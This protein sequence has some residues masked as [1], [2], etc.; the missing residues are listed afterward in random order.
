MYMRF[1][2][3]LV[4]NVTTKLH[5]QRFSKNIKGQNMKV[6]NFLVRDECDFKATQESIIKSKYKT[7]HMYSRRNKISDFTHRYSCFLT[8]IW[9][10]TPGLR[11]L[12][13]YQ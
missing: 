1:L 3:I 13:Y 9:S 7:T 2:G 11:V 6:S 12:V 8:P 10:E 4:M 5:R